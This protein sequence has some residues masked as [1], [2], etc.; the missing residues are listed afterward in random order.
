MNTPREQDA[1]H[2]VR[3]YG[4][5]GDGST[6]DTAAISEAVSAAGEEDGGTVYFPAG[7]FCTG[8]LQLPDHVTLAGDPGWSYREAGNSVLRLNDPDA[9]C[10]VD[11]S[12]ALAP[13]INGLTLD[14]N[15]VGRSCVGLLHDKTRDERKDP[16]AGCHLPVIE[17]TCV[18]NFTGDGMMFSVGVSAIRQCAIAR[19]DGHGI[20]YHK[21]A[22]CF[23]S[24]NIIW[25]NSGAGFYACDGSGNTTLT[26]NRIEHNGAGGLVAEHA[27]HYSISGN[28]FD[29]NKNGPSIWLRQNCHDF[30][31]SGNSLL[32]G[33]VFM[34]GKVP[35]DDPYLSSNFRAEHSSGVTLNGNGIQSEPIGGPANRTAED[36][37]FPAYGIVIRGL[38]VAAIT[39]NHMSSG[40]TRELIVDLGE[41]EDPARVAVA[42]N[43][44]SLHPSTSG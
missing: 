1:W 35:E 10:L 40:A 25:A 12:C 27:W 36:P 4:A 28:A 43:P 13:R 18:A 3:D 42:H 26:G 8:Q 38:N 24:D 6:D 30:V 21:G 41:H 17:R 15:G 23:I 33:G 2:N 34:D 11:L 5:T 32:R 7:T 22:D 9:D 37:V 16:P 20:N 14:G 31:I 39:G 44:G 29:H 19:N